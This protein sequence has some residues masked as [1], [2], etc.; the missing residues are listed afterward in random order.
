V[1]D[2][3]IK[4][5]AKTI[6]PGIRVTSIRPPTHT[7]NNAENISLMGVAI[8]LETTCTLDSAT[9]TPLQKMLQ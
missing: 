8:T 9:N 1:I 5:T 6:K 4:I 2:K 7:K 3:S